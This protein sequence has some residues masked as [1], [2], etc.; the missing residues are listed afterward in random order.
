MMHE[1]T[2]ERHSGIEDD[3]PRPRLTVVE[4]PIPGCFELLPA[5]TADRRG[6]FSK[7]FHRPQWRDLGLKTEFAEEYTT[8]SLPGTLRGLHFQTPPMAHDKVVLCLRGSAF[9][10]AVDLRVGSPAYGRHITVKLNHE[11]LNALYIPAGVA[12]G[13][14]VTGEEALLYY[15]VTTVYSP[16]HDSGVR[17]DSVGIDWPVEQ[18][19]LSDRDLAL[20]RFEDF[21]SPFTY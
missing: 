20:P 5:L 7:V 9:D 1:A 17:W 11:R 10:V 14:C 16:L 15:K 4:T 8:Y 18:P 3:C 6:S 21:T 12:H 19:T 2:L 13:F